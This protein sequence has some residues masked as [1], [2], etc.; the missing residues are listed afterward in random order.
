MRACVCVCARSTHPRHAGGKNRRQPP[1]SLSATPV[2]W[3]YLVMAEAL[4]SNVCFKKKAAL[5]P[6]RPSTTDW[7]LVC[8]SMFSRMCVCVCVYA[9]HLHRTLACAD[10]VMCLLIERGWGRRG[11]H[12]ASWDAVHGACQLLSLRYHPPAPAIP[13]SHTP[14]LRPPPPRPPP[15]PPPLQNKDSGSHSS[16]IRGDRRSASI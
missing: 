2:H 9:T 7:K 5:C 12:G 14:L 16:R 3:N 10:S 13:I 1:A 11:Q 8:E 15:P 6:L 4:M